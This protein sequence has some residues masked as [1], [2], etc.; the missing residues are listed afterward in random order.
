MKLTKVLLI[1]AGMLA[2]PA[3]VLA[4]SR[5]IHV[6]WEYQYT[7]DLAGFRLYQENNLACE[8]SDPNATAMECTVDAPD[9]ES[10]FTLTSFMQDGSESLPSAPFSYIFSSDLKAIL[11]ADTLAGESPLPVAFD[12]TSSTGN[13]ISYEWLFGDGATGIGNTII[14]TFASAGSYTVTLRVTDDL[15]ATDQETLEIT[16]T[17][18]TITNT[19]PFAVI[20]SSSSVGDAPL[21][22]QFD[23]SGST[24]SDGSILSYEWDMGDGGTATGPQVTYTYTTAGTFNATLSVIDDGGLTDSISTPVL[25]NEPQ[26]GDN[27]PPNAVIS[28][29]TN[30]GFVPLAVSFDAAASSDPDGTIN[31]YSWNFGDGATA[32]GILVNHVFTQAAVYTI[33][34]DV[35]DNMGASSQAS[36]NITVESGTPEPSSPIIFGEIATNDNWTRVDLTDNEF[37]HPV[38]IVGPPSYNESDPAVVRI[39]NVDAT[40]FD[41]RIQEWDYL[42]GL[43]A[44][45]TVHYIVLEQGS[46]TLDNGAMVEA[47]SFTGTKQPQSFNTPFQTEPVVFTAVSSTNEEDAVSGRIR[48]LTTSGFEYKLTEQEADKKSKH[49]EQTVGYIAWE[50]GTGNIGQLLYEVV[51][52]G[53]SVTDQWYQIDFQSQFTESP[54]FFAAMQSYNSRKNAAVRRHN[55]SATDVLIKIEGEASRDKKTVRAPRPEAVGYMIFSLDTD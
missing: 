50:P 24:D 19:P 47:G 20:S 34:L 13:I 53:D 30:Q 48:R 46:Y 37:V 23:G 33:T 44:D 1:L 15:G 3:L 45:E 9:G 42:D 6:E 51:T 52:T 49:A 43:H 2:L 38:V 10:L 17:N 8:T 25:V 7:D 40:G 39:R 35:T 16:V 36:Y 12:A 41:I 28:S 22:V 31:N 32:S 11:T 18:P 29:S 54:F 55:L 21:Q 14:Y 26:G 5:V 27:M 4:Q